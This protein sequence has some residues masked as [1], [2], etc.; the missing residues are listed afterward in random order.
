MAQTHRFECDV[1]RKHVEQRLAII[2]D[3]SVCAGARTSAC[4]PWDSYAMTLIP[5]AATLR[6]G[7]RDAAGVASYTPPLGYALVVW[8]FWA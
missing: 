8:V 2:F 7:P 4:A 6:A 1:G 5:M 3:A